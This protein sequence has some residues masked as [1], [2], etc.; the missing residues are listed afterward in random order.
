MQKIK[1]KKRLKILKEGRKGNWGNHYYDCI[2][3]DFTI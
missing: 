2:L 1:T 3:Y